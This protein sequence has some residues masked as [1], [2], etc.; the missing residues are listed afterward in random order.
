MDELKLLIP[1]IIAVLG[2][3]G[4]GG[5]VIALL[6]FKAQRNKIDSETAVQHSSSAKLLAEVD[7][8]NIANDKARLALVDDLLERLDKVEA[9]YLA[10]DEKYKSSQMREAALRGR[11]SELE[12]KLI[13]SDKKIL[14][15]TDKLTDC[16]ERWGLVAQAMK[17]A[18]TELELIGS[19][20]SALEEI[21]SN[22]SPQV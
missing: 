5:G 20:D 12:S 11:V 10:T 18:S 14:I 19:T 17:T 22:A 3:G 2:G 21:K 8:L 6:L 4:L 9:N 16:L 15:L 13:E 1:L 7:G